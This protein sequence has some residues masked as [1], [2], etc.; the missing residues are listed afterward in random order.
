MIAF[1]GIGAADGCPKA[2]PVVARHVR[3]VGDVACPTGAGVRR[4]HHRLDLEQGLGHRQDDFAI[5]RDQPQV[6]EQRTRTETVGLDQPFVAE[7]AV[8]LREVAGGRTRMLQSSLEL[9]RKPDQTWTIPGTN[10]LDR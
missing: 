2:L 8:A 4:A 10:R 9:T 7:V 1:T 5:G 6:H 3:Y